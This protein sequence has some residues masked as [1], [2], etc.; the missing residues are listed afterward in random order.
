MD[1][2]KDPWKD[3]ERGKEEDYFLR[4]HREWLEKKQGRGAAAPPACPACG[5]A[6]EAQDLR[7][8]AV[9]RC[10]DCGGAWLDA[11]AVDAL[12]K[13]LRPPRG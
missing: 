8:V 11:E 3:V 4:K 1:P 9:R 13:V 5:S 2:R 7:G 12:D 6:L 10:P